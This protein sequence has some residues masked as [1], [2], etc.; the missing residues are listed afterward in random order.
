MPDMAREHLIKKYA[1]RRLYDTTQSQHVTVDDLCALI[2]DGNTIRVV[3]DRTGEDITRSVLLQVITEQE[4][5]S[6]QP[7]L[8]TALLQSLIRFYGNPLQAY[9]SRFLEESAT[10]FIDEQSRLQSEVEAF[11]ENMPM[12]DLGRFARANLENWQKLQ[13]DMLAALQPD[14][15]NDRDEDDGA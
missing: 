13:Q 5:H 3:D 4:S 9:F 10:R 11:M 8:S 14:P 1:N 2:L 12:G 7:I 15:R 6:G